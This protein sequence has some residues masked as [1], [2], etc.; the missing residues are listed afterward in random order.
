MNLKNQVILA[1]NLADLDRKALFVIYYSGHGTCCSGH[2]YAHTVT[3]EEINLDLHVQKLASRANSYVIGFFDCCRNII[4][5]KGLS[6][7]SVKAPKTNGQLYVIYGTP[8]GHAAL[9]IKNDELS[10]ATKSFLEHLNG[11]QDVMFPSSLM[12]WQAKSDGIQIVDQAHLQV[13]I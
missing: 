4:E 8:L 9:D 11:K 3:S 2:T 7:Q 13:K 12:D 5:K 6:S 1:D 10:K